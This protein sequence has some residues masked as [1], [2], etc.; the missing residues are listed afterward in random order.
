MLQRA[1]RA[2]LAAASVDAALRGDYASG[3]AGTTRRSW[4]VS[5]RTRPRCSPRSRAVR[6]ALSEAAELLRC[7]RAAGVS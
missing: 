5:G 4:S 7:A 6:G 2:V 3:G 1:I